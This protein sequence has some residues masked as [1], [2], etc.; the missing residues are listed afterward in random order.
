MR[1]PILC[2]VRQAT[3]RSTAA[4]ETIRSTGALETIRSTGAKARTPYCS[5]VVNFS[6]T[7]TMTS[8]V[9]NT[10]YKIRRAPMVLTASQPL[11][12][13]NFRT[14]PL[15]YPSWCHRRSIA[16]TIRQKGF[17][18]IPA[19]RQ[20]PRSSNKACRT[21]RW[22]AL[23]FI[24]AMLRRVTSLMCTAFTI[25]F[26]M[27]TFIRRIAT[28]RNTSEQTLQILEMRGSLFRLTSKMVLG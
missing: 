13:R 2:A 10:L 24:K 27:L 25:K 19:R 15:S 16:S 11:N 20:R 26:K 22:R 3:T 4:L 8:T 21:S 7:L 28:K 9:D 17:I 23:F 5:V 12:G 14:R 6:T 1:L 18:F